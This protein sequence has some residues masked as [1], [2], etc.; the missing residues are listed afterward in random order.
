MDERKILENTFIF[1][2]Q[3]SSFEDI[4]KVIKNKSIEAVIISKDYNQK[5]LLEIYDILNEFEI[6][7]IKIVNTLSNTN[8]ELKD[9][10]VEDLLA[11]YPKDLDK[12]KIEAFIKDKVVLITGAGGSIGSEIFRQCQ[13]F[14]AKISTSSQYSYKYLCF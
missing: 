10:G 12:D 4:K 8:T 9:I 3:V 2:L 13:K 1:D 14:G 11:R 5:K 6:S 7:D